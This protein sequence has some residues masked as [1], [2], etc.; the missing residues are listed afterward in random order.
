MYLSEPPRRGRH[1]HINL[2]CLSPLFLFYPLACVSCVSV[3]SLDS[4]IALVE[5]WTRCPPRA[6][7]LITPH[8]FL[9]ILSWTTHPSRSRYLSYSIIKEEKKVPNLCVRIAK[10]DIEPIIIFLQSRSGRS[11]TAVLNYLHVASINE[12]FP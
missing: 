7:S 2:V 8:Q 1:Y 6:S 5:T 12:K 4:A 10:F 9:S 11:I 3:L